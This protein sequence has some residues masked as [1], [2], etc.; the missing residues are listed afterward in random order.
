MIALKAVFLQEERSLGGS[1]SDGGYISTPA[2][3]ISAQDD[4]FLSLAR[5][6]FV[7][8]PHALLFSLATRPMML[9][10]WKSAGAIFTGGQG[11]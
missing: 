4:I 9:Q 11:T 5:V 2:A 6:C 1:P 8:S 7:S 3:G 10:P